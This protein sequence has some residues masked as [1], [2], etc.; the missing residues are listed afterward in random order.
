MSQR[1]TKTGGAEVGRCAQGQQRF[2]HPCLRP[3][4]DPFEA[5]R[6]G[7]CTDVLVQSVPLWGSWPG[8]L[9]GSL[10]ALNR[11]SHG[12]RHNSV[13][14]MGTNIC[15]FGG[16]DLDLP[17]MKT[18]DLESQQVSAGVTPQNRVHKNDRD[19]QSIQI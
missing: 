1:V 18:F 17:Q 3:R 9:K 8:L 14:G 11:Q 5:V 15:P 10:L 13:K 16:A 7:V 2:A 19:E 4:L 12:G 6:D